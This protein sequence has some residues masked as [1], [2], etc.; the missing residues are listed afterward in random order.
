MTVFIVLTL[1]LLGITTGAAIN[2][3][4]NF[5]ILSKRKKKN[6]KE[7]EQISLM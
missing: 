7:H 6:K 3:L 4:R 2:H 5:Y 1:V